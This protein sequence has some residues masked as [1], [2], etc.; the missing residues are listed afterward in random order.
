[1]NKRSNWIFFIWWLEF[2][3]FSAWI[4]TIQ[5]SLKWLKCKIG[6]KWKTSQHLFICFVIIS[7]SFFITTNII[8]ACFDT[9]IFFLIKWFKFTSSLVDRFQLNS[10]STNESLLI[11]YRVKWKE[12][13]RDNQNKI[14]ILFYL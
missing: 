8:F 3:F 10:A 5:H 7:S 2:N 11:H 13:C 12:T 1:M 9:R 4:N 6:A 14:K